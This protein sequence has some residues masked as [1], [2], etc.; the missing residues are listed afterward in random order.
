MQSK[1]GYFKRL[2]KIDTHKA[3]TAKV[4][5]ERTNYKLQDENVDITTDLMTTV[6]ILK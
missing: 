3:K 1:I 2:I 4:K 5:R 6:K